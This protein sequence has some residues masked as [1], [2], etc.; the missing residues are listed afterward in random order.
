MM[1]ISR[2]DLSTG[3]RVRNAAGQESLPASEGAQSQAN[4]TL[5]L[6]NET[7]KLASI[8]RPA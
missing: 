2:S 4:P 8:I 3:K 7:R 1:A 5:T 6:M